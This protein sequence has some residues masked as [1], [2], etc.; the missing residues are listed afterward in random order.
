MKVYTRTYFL[1][2]KT[3]TDRLQKNLY[4]DFG[5]MA[6]TEEPLEATAQNLRLCTSLT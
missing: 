4:L 6:I 5:V 3:K 2:R 1:E